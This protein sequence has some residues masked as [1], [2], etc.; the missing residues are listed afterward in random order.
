[1]PVGTGRDLSLRDLSLQMFKNK[2][3]FLVQFRIGN[4]RNPLAVG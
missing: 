3:L 1:M 4:K 2:P